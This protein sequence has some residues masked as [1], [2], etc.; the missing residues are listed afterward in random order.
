MKQWVAALFM[1]VF[2]LASYAKTSGVGLDKVSEWSVTYKLPAVHC[3]I[4]LG[5]YE[6]VGLQNVGLEKDVFLRAFKGYL[7]LLERGQ[8][9]NPRIMTI[10]DLSQSSNNK[11]FYVIDL[12]HKKLAIHTYV[13][14]GK[15]SGSEMAISFS[16]TNNS[17]KSVLGFLVTANTYSGHYG[18]ALRLQGMEQGINHLVAQRAIVVHGSHYVHENEPFRKSGITNSLGCPAI[19]MTLSKRVIQLI[20]GGSLLYIHHPDEFYAQR[21]QLLNAN[22]HSLGLLPTFMMQSLVSNVMEGFPA[23]GLEK[24]TEAAF[25]L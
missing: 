18:T 14:H 15:N 20:Q 25:S 10:V 5:F 12:L 16:N 21:S 11:R 13:M 8:L 4:A 3:A 23:A 24:M 1:S 17:N 19:P 2:A 9:R 6:S 22:T 7:A